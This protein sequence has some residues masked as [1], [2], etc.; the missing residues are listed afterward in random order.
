MLVQFT[1]TCSIRYKVSIHGSDA[2]R[3][4][5][6]VAAGSKAGRIDN[7]AANGVSPNQEASLGRQP[8]FSC[9]WSGT[10]DS[11]GKCCSSERRSDPPERRGEPPERRGGR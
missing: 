3:A 1:T 9:S 6:E 11:L 5:N 8:K 2:L 7:K 4:V 10:M